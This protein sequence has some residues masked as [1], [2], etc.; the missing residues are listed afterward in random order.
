MS[1]I[2]NWGIIGAG[3]EKPIA[4]Y[5]RALPHFKYLRSLFT[6]DTIGKIDEPLETYR[7]IDIVLG[8]I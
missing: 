1:K 7:V 5:R 3:I 4:H 2:I 8:I 6:E